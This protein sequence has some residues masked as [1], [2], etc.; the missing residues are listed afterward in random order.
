MKLPNPSAVEEAEKN[1]DESE[2]EEEK[3]PLQNFSFYIQPKNS[4]III[5]K[6]W[7]QFTLMTGIIYLYH[8][9]WAIYGVDE[10]CDISR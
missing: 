8:I 7:G 9:I 4:Y 10:F 5:S 3:L 2:K 1:D 6:K